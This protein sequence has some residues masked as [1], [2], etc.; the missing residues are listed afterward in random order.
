[1]ATTTLVQET[2]SGSATS[3]SYVTTTQLDTYAA[4]RNITL[5]GTYGDQTEVLFKAI[6][7][8]DAL[9]F[10]GIKWTQ[11]QAMQWPRVDAYIDGYLL[12]SDSIPV[13]LTNAQLAI[14]LEIDQ[15]N[16]PL[17]VINRATK[18]EK[19]DVIEVEYME[20]SS[21]AEIIRSVSA[22]LR[23][24]LRAGSSGANFQVSRL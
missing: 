24:L 21:S 11:A 3:N 19:V 17:A 8:L 2:G 22:R 18:K 13:E 4:D 1:M 16:D 7:Y 12:D 10:I 23:K 5:S 6:D 15:G 20:N 9:P 14:A